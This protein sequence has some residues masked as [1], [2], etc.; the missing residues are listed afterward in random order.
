LYG[1]FSVYYGMSA[2]AADHHSR[3]K[4]RVAGDDGYPIA[5][6]RYITYGV[7]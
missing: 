3:F 7:V 4:F 6:D 5:G 1:Y 2:I